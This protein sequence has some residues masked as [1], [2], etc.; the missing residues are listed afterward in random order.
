[1]RRTLPWIAFLLMSFALT[2]LVGLFAS[3]SV[4]IPLER[5]LSRLATAEG[6]AR[7]TI[8]AETR[9]EHAAVAAR[10]RLM[11]GLVTVLGGAV[12]AGA[13]L[14]ATRQA[15]PPPQPGTPSSRR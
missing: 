12:G 1:M 10:T 5:G 2:G 15:G 7:A 13:L 6:E 11:I 9:A 14:F 4:A 8:I 3:Y